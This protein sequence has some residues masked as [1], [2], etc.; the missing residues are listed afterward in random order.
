MRKLTVL[1]TALLAGAAGAVVAIPA[2]A[3]PAVCALHCDTRDPSLARQETF[4]VPEVNLNGRRLVLHVSDIDRMAWGSIDN[5][6]LGDSVWLD[7][8]W[9]D[10]STWDGLLGRASIP[11]TWTGTRTLM[12]NVADPAAHR[13]GMVRACGD[14]GGVT[15]TAWVYVKVCDAV[16]DGVDAATAVGDS[17]PV[18][19]TTIG[20]RRIDL[21]IDSRGLAWATLGSGAAGDEV[22]LDRSWDEGASW[23]GG[24]SLGRVSVPAGAS[25]VRTTMVNTRDPRSLLYGGA[26]RACGRATGGA[27]GSCTAWARPALD[28]PAA[29]A[30]ALAHAYRTDTAWWPSSWWNSAVAV[31]ALGDWSARTGRTDYRWLIDRTYELNKGVMPAG[32][33]STDAIEGNF[34]SRAIDDTGWWAL[35]WVQA[36]DVTRDTKYLNMAVTIANYMHSYWD[37][38]CG[39]GIWWNRERT[40]KNA[41][42]IGLYIRLT[43]ALHNRLAGD[44]LWLGRATAG[45]NWFA[46]SGMINSAGL[47]NDGIT[48]G[49]ANNGQTVWTYNQGLAIGGAVEL[50]RATGNASLLASARQLAD[51]AMNSTVLTRSGILTESCDPANSCDDN[52]KQFKGIFMRYLMD[53]ADA[54]GVAA[55]RTYAQRQA[56][57]IWQSDRDSLNRIGLRWAGGTPNARDWRTQASGL[58]ALLAATAGPSTPPTPPPSE[59]AWAPNVSYAA[60]TVVTYTGA[61]WQCRQPHLSQV[62]WEPP[63]VAALW[64]RL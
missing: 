11:A 14:A 53:L 64:L 30:D 8:S 60:G 26:V 41:V 40:Y 52:Q 19:G 21:H 55:Y 36:Y 29:A 50:W 45:W 9:T 25:S 59:A 5:G 57:A 28:R 16:C 49:C 2:S 10:G 44:T 35:A 15:C 32:Q 63:N 43:A 39:G 46:A 54:S 22:W 12:Y 4:P 37:G 62:G 27:G 47:V 23:P 6:V 61:R 17:Q 18:P 1:I 38:S 51:A 42:T 13:R 24:S 48:G 7:R 58:G 56:D 34:I 33:K 3:A 31:T 20:N